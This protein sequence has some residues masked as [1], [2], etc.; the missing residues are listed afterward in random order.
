MSSATLTVT[1]NG[2]LVLHFDFDED[3][4]AGEVLDVS[5]SGNNGWQMDATNWIIPYTISATTTA[6][7]WYYNGVMTNAPPAIYNKSQYIAVTNLN[8]F[9][10]LTNGTISLWAK[11]D[12]NVDAGIQLLSSSMPYAN[13]AAPE[14][15]YNSWSLG[16]IGNAG[17]L[18]FMVCPISRDPLVVT[19]VTWPDDSVRPGG[20]SPDLSTAGFHLYTVTIDC[21]ANQVIAYHDGQPYQTNTID[22]PWIR[23]Y[24]CS[25]QP[26]LCV[27][28][29]AH[30]GTP[31]WGDDLYP[32][33]GFF[34]GKL[35]DIR[36]YNR[37]LSAAEVGNLYSGSVAVY[38]GR[39]PPAPPMGVRVTASGS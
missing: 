23:V 22:L 18:G 26:W 37:T 24:G 17:T 35:D 30:D 19:V 10:F 36:I 38:Q 7:Q 15:D 27:G 20:E 29:D 4:S 28:A 34:V 39:Q 9:G 21:P 33:S 8:G 6:G 31:Q 25:S 5:G 32:N 16:R 12:A 13:A 14:Q 11:F 1:T 2:G 3:F